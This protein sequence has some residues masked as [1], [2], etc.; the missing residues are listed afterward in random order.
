M[1][2]SQFV[3]IVGHRY[4]VLDIRKHGLAVFRACQ[5]QV[6]ESA[7]RAREPAAEPGQADRGAEQLQ[8]PQPTPF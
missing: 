3:S 1:W 4:R 5:V 6:P 8:A 7:P 2:L